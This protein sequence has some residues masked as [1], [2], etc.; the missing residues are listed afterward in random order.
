MGTLVGG[1]LQI[2]G[3]IAIILGVCKEGSSFR[4]IPCALLRFD[5]LKPLLPCL[6]HLEK[7]C[8]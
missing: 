7:N 5:L 4:N 2:L 8:L 3:T 1:I 6:I